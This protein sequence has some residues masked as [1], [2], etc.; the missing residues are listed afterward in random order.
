MKNG[1]LAPVAFLSIWFGLMPLAVAEDATFDSNGVKIR[2]VSEGEGDA[3][4]LLH[5][6]MS[7]ATMWGRDSAGNPKLSPQPGFRVIAMDC[8]GHG[9][10]D[11]PHDVNQY[12]AEMAA[13]VVRLLDHLK[14][15]KAQIV[16]YSMGSF[17]AGKVA[18]TYPDRVTSVIYGGQAPLLTGE[19]GS[20]EVDAFAKAVA[21]GKGMGAYILEVSPSDRPKP[22]PA[23]AEAYANYL[24]KGKDTKALAASGLSFDRLEV[25]LS[26]LQRCSVPIMFVFGSKEPANLKE[27]VGK[28]QKQ[29]SKVEVKEISGAD[30]MTTLISPEFGSAVVKFLQQNKQS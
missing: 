17:I 21:D 6:W 18:A 11:K 25:T 7:D 19:A 14:I 29:L 13:D 4:V 10:S 26:D 22:T 2:Y 23:Q 28:L 27:R 24:F 9:K 5:G 15:K 12:G 3:V 16:G 20:R 30:H 8:R 1:W